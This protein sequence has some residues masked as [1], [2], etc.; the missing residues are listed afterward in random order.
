MEAIGSG[1]NSYSFTDTHPT[2]GINYY[3]LKS[4]DKD[5]A[6]TYSKV[7]SIQLTIDNYKLSIIPNPARDVVT[8]KGNHVA[9]VQVIDNIGRVVKVVTLKDAT[10]PTLSV[11]NLQAGVY[12]LRIQTSDG[13]VSAVGMVKE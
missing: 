2:N 13:E 12:Q 10:N 4:V 3:R 9:Y 7:V 1:A 11:S 8:V 5:G 6:V